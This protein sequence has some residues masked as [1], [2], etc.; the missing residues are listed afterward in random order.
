MTAGTREYCRTFSATT[1]HVV[2]P[3]KPDKTLCGARVST[4]CAGILRHMRDMY[5]G[6][7]T[8]EKCD[9]SATRRGLVEGPEIYREYQPRVI[10]YNA[11]FDRLACIEDVDIL[12]EERGGTATLCGYGANISKRL[13]GLQ[14]RKVCPDCQAQAEEDGY[15]P[16]E[17]I[18][19]RIARQE[20]VSSK[21]R[22]A[23]PDPAIVDGP[24]GDA[25]VA[26]LVRL[27]LEA[28]RPA[29]DT[30]VMGPLWS[31]PYGYVTLLADGAYAAGAWSVTRNRKHRMRVEIAIGVTAA[32]PD[33]DGDDALSQALA[34]LDKILLRNKLA[35][36]AHV[37]D[38]YRQPITAREAEAQQ[39]GG[40]LTAHGLPTRFVPSRHIEP[41][42]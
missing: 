33:R 5:Y 12:N 17:M 25:P 31:K 22:T 32:H 20:S 10:R 27:D 19:V 3:A 34:M 28:G 36:K 9:A 35:A 15:Y 14:G 2:N 40:Y 26:W 1:K 42:A 8:C 13:D 4:H 6:L 38:T 30:E 11:R 16:K 41:P 7:P 37:V 24:D 23:E 29:W 21:V 18:D 39:S